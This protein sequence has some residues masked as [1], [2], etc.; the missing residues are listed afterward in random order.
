MI[1]LSDLPTAGSNTSEGHV[2][3]D[4]RYDSTWYERD[5]CG[6]DGWSAATAGRGGTVG[7]EACQSNGSTVSACCQDGEGGVEVWV[8]SV[9]V[10][11]GG[12][13]GQECVRG[14]WRGGGGVEGWGYECQYMSDSLF[15]LYLDLFARWE[16]LDFFDKVFGKSHFL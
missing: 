7:S 11:G 3:T 16:Y 4:T 9:C 15:I 1:P 13:A 8:M 2:C 10:C 6:S 5:G 12:G 14:V